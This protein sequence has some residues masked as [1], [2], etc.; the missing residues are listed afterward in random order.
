MLNSLYV[1]DLKYCSDLLDFI[2]F[3]DDTFTFSKDKIDT[4]FLTVNK[5][6]QNINPWFISNKLSLNII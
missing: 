6:Y 5:E 1:N 4:L 2:M 3:A